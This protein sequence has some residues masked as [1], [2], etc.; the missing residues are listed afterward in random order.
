MLC[1]PTVTCLDL[2]D[3]QTIAIPQSSNKEH[4]LDNLQAAE[5]ELT[6]A[7]W[8]KIDA[9]FPKPTTKQPL[10]VL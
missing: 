4:V 3:N 7:E 9:A 5:L 8:Q 10:A 1:F 2:R 6:E